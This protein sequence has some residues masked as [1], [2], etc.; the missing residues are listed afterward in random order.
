MILTVIEI[1]E[2]AKEELEKTFNKK[3]DIYKDNII[4]KILIIINDEFEIDYESD[5]Y[6]CNILENIKELNLKDMKKDARGNIIEDLKEEDALKIKQLISLYL[7]KSYEAILEI[8]KRKR[9]L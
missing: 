2:F 7:I 1:A 3:F 8:L 4:D 5:D 6:V 9:M